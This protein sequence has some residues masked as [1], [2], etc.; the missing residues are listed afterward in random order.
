M[1]AFV[2]KIIR[3][4]FDSDVHIN[5]NPDLGPFDKRVLFTIGDTS[6]PSGYSKLDM[7]YKWETWSIA[8]LSVPE[9]DREKEMQ[10]SY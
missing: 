8:G 3:E 2:R 7:A 4:S 6:I 1:R 10:Q 5:E 9:K